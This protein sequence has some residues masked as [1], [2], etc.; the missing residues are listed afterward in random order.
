[1]AISFES[2]LDL[3]G[4]V[5]FKSFLLVDGDPGLQGQV[6]T[7]QGPGQPAI[8]DAGSEIDPVI[9]GMIF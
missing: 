3:R 2:D 8:W 4:S 7:S 5:D 9:S 6:L 1:M